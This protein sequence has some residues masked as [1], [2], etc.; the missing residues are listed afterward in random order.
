MTGKK[1]TVKNE[2]EEIWNEICDLPIEMYAL[3]DQRVKDHINKLGNHGDSVIVRPKSPAG[4][5]ALEATLS[6]LGGKYQ[7]QT[8]EGGYIMVCR[9]PKSLVEEEDFILFPRPDGK[10][11][12]VPRKKLYNS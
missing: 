1:V 11:D 7:L 9:T 2:A 8:A 10:V 3:P 5:P 6:T 4:L 12:K